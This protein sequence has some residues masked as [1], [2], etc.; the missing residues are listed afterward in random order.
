MTVPEGELVGT[1]LGLSENG[2]LL[3]KE[4]ADNGSIKEIDYA[5]DIRKISP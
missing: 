1:V 2:Y 3:I 4:M 5:S